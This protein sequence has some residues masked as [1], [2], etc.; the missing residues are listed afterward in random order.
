M[1]SVEAFGE[2]NDILVRASSRSRIEFRF[3]VGEMVPIRIRAEQGHGPN[4]AGQWEYRSL[5]MVC[6]STHPVLHHATDIALVPSILQH[7]IKAGQD[8][9][10]KGGKNEIHLSV[11]DPTKYWVSKKTQYDEF[12]CAYQPYEFSSQRKDGRYTNCLVYID[13]V[14]AYENG[15]RVCQSR[16]HAGLSC[17][18]I[19]PET[20]IGYKDL[21]TG[22]YHQLMLREEEPEVNSDREDSDVSLD[23][24]QEDGDEDMDQARADRE[25]EPAHQIHP[26]DPDIPD[27][28]PA[29]SSDFTLADCEME[30]LEYHT[31]P[32][33]WQIDREVTSGALKMAEVRKRLYAR[34]HEAY[35]GSMLVLR[36]CDLS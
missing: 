1:F 19:P 6:P 22:Q 27:A 30:A 31:T 15:V 28:F 8:L 24:V 12:G 36:L 9:G 11:M 7:G 13:Y 20:L 21:N 18:P 5:W 29:N 2:L 3:N 23:D 14:A 17:T 26:L 25:V 35:I 33:L 10:P 16:S 4:A 32:S 34:L